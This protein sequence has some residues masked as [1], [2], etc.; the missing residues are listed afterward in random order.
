L[1][2]HYQKTYELVL[3]FWERRN[4]QFVSLAAVLAVAAVGSILQ[5]ALIAAARIY[6]E[7]VLKDAKTNVSVVLEALPQAYSVVMTFLLV[8]SFYLM[9]NLYLQTSLIINYY[10]YIDLLE[11]DLRAELALSRA[12]VAFTREGAYYSSNGQRVSALVRL[13]Y[14]LV[15]F[16]LLVLLFASRMMVDWP[17]DLVVLLELP[18][19]RIIGWLGKNYLFILDV[20]LCGLTMILFFAYAFLRG[21]PAI[22]PDT[23]ARND[24]A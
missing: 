14:K 15:L 24:G 10:G 23:L 11:H 8:A 5:E 1:A 2:E 7:T 6:L 3:H 4:R 22:V 16:A 21:K 12:R 19:D 18:P 13:F 20:L 9:A 17:H